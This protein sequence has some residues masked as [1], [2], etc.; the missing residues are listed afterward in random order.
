[1]NT[2][3]VYR[4]IVVVAMLLTSAAPVGGV[5]MGYVADP[6][7]IAY[8]VNAT[9]DAPDVSPGDGKCQTSAGV[10]TLRAAIEESTPRYDLFCAE[11]PG[12]DRYDTFLVKSTILANNV[13]SSG[14]RD[15][16]NTDGGSIISLGYNLVEVPDNCTF[17]GG[18][19]TGI[20]PLLGPLADHGGD[21]LTHAP[22][23]GSPALDQGSCVSPTLTADQ[24]GWPRPMDIL[25][26]PNAADGC[27]IGAYEVQEATIPPVQAITPQVGT[28]SLLVYKIA[29]MTKITTREEPEAGMVDPGK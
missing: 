11:L 8:T 3:H 23:P 29:T 24:R 19:I 10:C 21:T 5:A 14:N 26:I 7:A 16:R 13:D 25:S 27:N 2:L 4:S 18:D 28:V 1:M 22:L 15:C 17:S 6:L 9:E 20:D 12:D